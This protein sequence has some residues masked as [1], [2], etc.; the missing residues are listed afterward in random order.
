[1]SATEGDAKYHYSEESHGSTQRAL[2]PDAKLGGSIGLSIAPLHH[3]AAFPFLD[4][5]AL[6]SFF[7]NTLAETGEIPLSAIRRARI[8]HRKEPVRFARNGEWTFVLRSATPEGAA[9]LAKVRGFHR[10]RRGG[11]R[12]LTTDEKA[13]SSGKDRPRNDIHFSA[14]KTEKASGSKCGPFE[15]P[16]EVRGKQGKP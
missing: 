15:A 5:M 10:F 1:L 6:Y 3:K 7:S 13:D 4:G 14:A 9:P 11:K 2:G 8:V 16:L 12:A